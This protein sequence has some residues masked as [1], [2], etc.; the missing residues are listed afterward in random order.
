MMLST[1]RL[2]GRDFEDTTDRRVQYR[3]WTDVPLPVPG[4]GD[5]SLTHS[6][7]LRSDGRQI[8]PSDIRT[9]LS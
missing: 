8:H 5:C 1:A 4:N 9:V 7:R 6:S 2:F 3:S